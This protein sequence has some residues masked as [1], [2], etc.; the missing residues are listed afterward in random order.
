M[1]HDGDM[2]SRTLALPAM[3]AM[4]CGAVATRADQAPDPAAVP[5]KARAA[6]SGNGEWQPLFDGESLGGWQ[7]VPFKRSGGV[8]VENGTIVLGK[9]PATAIRWTRPFP[10]SNY[11]IRLEAARLDGDDFFAGITFPV[12]EA[13]CTWI[14]GGWGGSL[15]GLSSLEGND[16]SENE[17]GTHKEFEN[18]RWYALRLRVTDDRIQAWIDGE[19]IISIALKDREVGL[20]FG[21]MEECVPLGI[22]SWS[23]TGAVRK[24][25]YRT[26]ATRE[27]K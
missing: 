23:T 25:E 20:R 17:T 11:E 15:V 13:H 6:A 19:E 26:V 27:T 14:N 3:A 22:A 10:K 16:A 7:Q 5:G 24:L 2:R 12:K 18:G 1:P 21:E 4:L 9:G 8:R